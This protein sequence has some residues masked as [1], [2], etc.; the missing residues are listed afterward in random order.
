MTIQVQSALALDSY[1]HL[2]FKIKSKERRLYLVRHF[3]TRVTGNKLSESNQSRPFLT[4]H[5]KFECHRIYFFPFTWKV[6]SNQTFE[7]SVED[8]FSILPVVSLSGS[9]YPLSRHFVLVLTFGLLNY[10]KLHRQACDLQI[11][12]L[13]ILAKMMNL[14]LIKQTPSST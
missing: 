3:I 8:Q 5:H 10:P 11:V 13:T 2:N 9:I 12:L 1:P 6:S 14:N 4:A 7:I